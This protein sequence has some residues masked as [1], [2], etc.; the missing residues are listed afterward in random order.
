MAAIIE[1]LKRTSPEADNQNAISML[2]ILI[3]GTAAY[4]ETGSAGISKDQ[5]KAFGLQMNVANLG[6]E[7]AI[8]K[9]GIYYHEGIGVKKDDVKAYEWLKRGADKGDAECSTNLA[10]L[11]INSNVKEALPQAEKYLR[12]AA[13]AGHR[14]AIQALDK[15]F[16]SKEASIS[17]AL[18]KGL[19]TNGNYYFVELMGEK[20]EIPPGRDVCKNRDSPWLA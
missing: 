19:K 3:S 7:S 8:N 20:H 6:E 11:I 12:S 10:I 13:A 4:Y 15:H 9:V 14:D 17:F 2:A 5:A 1:A 16:P 18:A